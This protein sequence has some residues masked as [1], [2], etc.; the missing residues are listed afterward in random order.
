MACSHQKHI[1]TA[2]AAP[3]PIGP[4]SVAVKAGP[5]LFC[6]G[7]L[8][9]VPETG[10]IIEGGIEEETRQACENIKRVLEAAGSSLENVVKTTVFLRDM[11]EF[12]KMNA[13]YGEFFGVQSPARS[14]VQAAALPKFAAVEIE[15]IALAAGE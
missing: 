9:L 11:N 4:Y 15:V 7:Q 2:Q 5:F 1:I 3:K 6:S 13:V 10:N 8:G 14:A 12:A